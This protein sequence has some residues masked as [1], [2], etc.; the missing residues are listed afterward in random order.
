MTDL[1]AREVP[2]NHRRFTAAFKARIVR[3][4]AVYIK[5]IGT[6]AEY[7]KVDA[8]TVEME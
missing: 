3:F 2:Q 8:E 5:F 4:G 1:S 6:H 7:G